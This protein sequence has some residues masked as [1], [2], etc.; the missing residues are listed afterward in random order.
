MKPENFMFKDKKEGSNLKLI[1]FGLSMSYYKIN[2]SADL[3]GNIS[4]IGKI[5]DVKAN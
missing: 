3:K 5:I 1:D 2:N 4:N